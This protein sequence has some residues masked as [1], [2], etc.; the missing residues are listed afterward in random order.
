[1]DTLKKYNREYRWAV[2]RQKVRN[3]KRS[4]RIWCMEHPVKALLVKVAEYTVLWVV[5]ILAVVYL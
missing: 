5:F 1:M 3:L 4:Y 2:R